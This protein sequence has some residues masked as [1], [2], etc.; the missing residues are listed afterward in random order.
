MFDFTLQEH[1]KENSDL[2]IACSCWLSLSHQRL[3]EGSGGWLF[4]LLTN[5]VEESQHEDIDPEVAVV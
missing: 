4:S 5:T 3:E 2:V 1:F